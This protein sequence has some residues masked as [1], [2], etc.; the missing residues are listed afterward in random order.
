MG[1]TETGCLLD[2]LSQCIPCSENGHSCL[3]LHVGSHPLILH[4]AFPS[5]ILGTKASMLG[6]PALA[7]A[8]S[9]GPCQPG[10]IVLGAPTKSRVRD[11]D[12]PV[13]G[14]ESLSR[15]KRAWR[16]RFQ[17]QP[18]HEI[19]CVLLWGNCSTSWHLCSLSLKGE[20]GMRQS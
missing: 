11:N 4:P 10:G 8:N 6:I 18:C 17:F 1:P 14:V 19:C 2:A 20:G 3:S 7:Q 9:W 15:D 13:P 5:C 12:I 16:P